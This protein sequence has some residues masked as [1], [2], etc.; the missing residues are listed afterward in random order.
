MIIN[1]K[2]IRGTNIFTIHL[3]ML[4]KFL[5]GSRNF[6]IFPPED[7]KQKRTLVML[8]IMEQIEINITTLTSSF[9]LFSVL[10]VVVLVSLKFLVMFPL[11]K[12]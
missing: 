6:I 1:K 9:L 12:I 10:V 4:S 8:I 7:I 11:W 3:V 2:L 5:H